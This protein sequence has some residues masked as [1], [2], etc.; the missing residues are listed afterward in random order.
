MASLGKLAAGVVHELNDPLTS[1]SVYAEYLVKKLASGNTDSYDA[2]K[3][4]RI[5]EGA[6]RI[7]K[8]TRDLVSY[9]R[10]SSE[11]PESLQFNDLITQ[12]LSFCEHTIRKFDVCVNTDLLED[13]P[14]IV[15]NRTQLLQLIINLVTN[16]CQAMKGGGELSLSTNIK[17]S[18]A[19][20]LTVSDTGS[21]IPARD[22]KRIFEPFYTTKTDGEGTGLGLSI[23]SRIIEHHRG[24][25]DVTSAPGEGTTFVIHLALGHDQSEDG[26]QG[27]D[28]AV[29]D[30]S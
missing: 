20:V 16:A 28:M 8:L 14:E 13:L 23:A 10:P 15:G 4:E 6:R 26:S 18:R 24:R 12:G 27:A 19:L 30:A 11:E 25:I 9:G 21:G 3:M 7:Q 22:L 1:I 2:E 29:K 17:N 5:L